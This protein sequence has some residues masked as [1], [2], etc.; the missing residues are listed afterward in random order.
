MATRQLP[1]NPSLKSLKNQAK[2][3][4]HGQ[5][6]G[7]K[8]ACERIRTCHP[9]MATLSPEEIRETPFA[10]ADALLVI[11]REYGFESWPKL[12]AERFSDP[13]HF[14]NDAGWQWIMAPDIWHPIG[15]GC[16]TSSSQECVVSWLYNREDR[17]LSVHV[18]VGSRYTERTLRSVAFDDETNRYVM[19]LHGSA[20]SKELALY[21]FELP[22]TEVAY[23][24]ISQI[25]IEMRAQ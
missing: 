23:G 3:L 11:A 5:Q 6:S 7:A 19:H 17:G 20:K 18:A 2:Q 14:T 16:G 15:N 10:L 13:S 12:M 1:A 25:G 8:D 9:R 24:V 4:L 22:Y 21:G